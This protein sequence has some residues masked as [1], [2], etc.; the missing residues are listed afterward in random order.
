[1]QTFQETVEDKIR[2]GE[3]LDIST[4]EFRYMGYFIR[5][6]KQV[7]MAGKYPLQAA[8]RG[9]QGTVNLKVT[10]E[11]NGDLSNLVLVGS[12]GYELLDHSALKTMKRAG[13]FPP[14]PK[15]F[16]KKI[17]IKYDFIYSLSFFP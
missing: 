3:V 12:S 5:I 14:L 10:I 15:N 17:T 16:G 8:R 7:S 13:P 11:Q 9:M 6:R 1:M 4:E 2:R